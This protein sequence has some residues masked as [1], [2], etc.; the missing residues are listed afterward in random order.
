M[1]QAGAGALGHAQ[2][3]R[4]GARVGPHF[5][6]AGLDPQAFEAGIRAS[7]AR[8]ATDD[9]KLKEIVEP[10]LAAGV[11]MVPSM[12]VP[13]II[14]DGRLRIESASFDTDRVRVAIAGGYDLLADQADLRAVMMPINTR[15][16]S[17]R[18]D[19]RVDLNGSPDILARTVDV[20]GFQSW[21]SMRAIDR[22]TRRLDQLE[23]GVTSTPEPYALWDETLPK[24]DPLAP[25]EVRVPARDPR[26]KSAVPKAA[27]PRPPV[28]SQPPVTR[29]PPA[30]SHTG[31]AQVQPLPPPIDI[32]PAPGMLQK[33]RPAPSPASRTF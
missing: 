9:L 15:P 5:G 30:N 22:E 4:A 25:S 10:V 21:L 26:R 20:A 11:L 29:S 1:R 7:N 13:F 24:I 6:I 17:G 27:P 16:I 31:N 19:I 18:P 14:R 28:A 23:R 3:G 8:Q 12:Q 2:D 32:K 33:P